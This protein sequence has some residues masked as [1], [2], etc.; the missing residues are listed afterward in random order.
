LHAE[1][2]LGTGR[3]TSTFECSKKW[4]DYHGKVSSIWGLKLDAGGKVAG[5]TLGATPHSSSID[6]LADTFRIAS[7]TNG[8]PVTAFE[9]RNG[10]TYI[11]NAMIGDLTSQQIRTSSL[12]GRELMAT[13]VIRVGTGRNS[14]IM[15]GADPKWRIWAGQDGAEGAPFRVDKDGILYSR[16]GIFDGTIYA[17]QGEF[18][19]Q[20]IAKSG[21]ID[22]PLLLQNGSYISGNIAVDH[23]I[24]GAGGRF[25]VQ[26]N[27]DMSCQYANI[28]GGY[29][30][31]TTFVENLQ[32]DVYTKTFYSLPIQKTGFVPGGGDQRNFALFQ[33]NSSTFDRSMFF[34]RIDV[35]YAIYDSS[36]K[37]DV[38][39]VCE[40]QSPVWVSNYQSTSGQPHDLVDIRVRLPK[41]A[42]YV[43]FFVIS[44]SRTMLHRAT[45]CNG[46]CELSKWSDTNVVASS[47]V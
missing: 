10:T 12:T 8:T 14:A 45:P 38:Y 20:I 3:M 47:G 16:G 25:V 44:T 36:G 39:Y 30:R 13:S 7:S 4:G 33:V 31:G 34:S 19:G 15:S 1:T 11:R 17:R 5:M 18:S 6:F 28:S 29:F 27:G 26:Q 23:F 22:G 40:G 43:R 35:P 9:V 46:T 21:R 24:S 32:G 37:I 2:A 41:G 42:S